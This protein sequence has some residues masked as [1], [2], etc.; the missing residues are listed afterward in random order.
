METLL[1]TPQYFLVICHKVDQNTVLTLLTRLGTSGH[2][3]HLS[4]HYGV[5]IIYYSH[6]IY[7]KIPNKN[8]K[9]SSVIVDAIFLDS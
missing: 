3:L 2:W 6:H 4:G 7:V 8:G 9:P 5:G 1:L